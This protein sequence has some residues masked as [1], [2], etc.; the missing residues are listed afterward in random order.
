VRR[1]ISGAEQL[2]DLMRSDRIKILR[3]EET[4]EIDR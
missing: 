1:Q 2:C 3:Y 4:V